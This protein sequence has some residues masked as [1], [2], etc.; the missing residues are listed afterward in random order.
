MLALCKFDS[1]NRTPVTC[2]MHGPFF[3]PRPYV[4]CVRDIDLTSGL[5]WL[6]EM[7]PLQHASTLQPLIQCHVAQALRQSFFHLF[8]KLQDVPR[9]GLGHA[10]L[11]G[12]IIA[13]FQTF[14]VSYVKRLYFSMTLSQS[15]LQSFSPFKLI[16]ATK[17]RSSANALFIDQKSTCPSGRS[18]KRPRVPHIPKH[19]SIS[20]KTLAEAG[21]HCC[22]EV[23]SPCCK[24]YRRLIHRMGKSLQLQQYLGFTRSA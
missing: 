24:N 17:V 4:S 10:D 6:T 23:E 11:P 5:V 14:L 12:H 20:A 3:W 8:S 21:S 19:L 13:L 7:L 9:L 2:T 22:F 18:T 15:L 1:T 16:S